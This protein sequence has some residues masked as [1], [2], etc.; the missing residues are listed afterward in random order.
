M[1][2]IVVSSLF[3]LAT[4]LAYGDSL[5][6]ETLRTQVDDYRQPA[7]DF[8]REF[9]SFPNDARKP[10]DIERL[11]VW[12][13]AEFAE[14]GFRTQR[15]PTAGSDSLYA[16]REVADAKRTVLIYLQADG[17]P[18]DPSAWQQPD[19]FVPVLKQPDGKGGFEIIPWDTPGYDPDWRV[20]ARS[21]SD[22]KG[23]MA[24]FLVAIELLDAAGWTQDYTLKVLI[25]TEE[26]LGSPHLAN[27]VV[28]NADLLAADFLLIFDGPPHASDRPT[29]SFGAR[30]IVTLTLT[31]Y[32]PKRAQH[33]GHYGNFMP[34][35]AL[36]LAQLLASMKDDDGRV[37][38]DGF[39]D[40]IEIDEATRAVLEAVP[41]DED[42]ILESVGLARRDDVAP[43]LQEAL[44]YPS[45]NIRGL[46]SAW[47]GDQVR[48]IIPPTAVAEIDIRLVKESD[49]QRLVGLVEAHIE[50]Q[51]YYVI[52]RPP[53]D[54]ERLE[55]PRIATLVHD[56][57]YNAFRSPYD[58]PAG[59]MARAALTELYDEPPVL[60]RTMGGS[61]PISPIVDALG[62]PAATVPTVNIDNNQ[63]SPNENLRLGSFY[64]GIA[65]L[66]AVLAQTP[67]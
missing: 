65:R 19:P 44:Q 57:S 24:Q 53:T 8:F 34:N 33:S 18:V 9:L 22:S 46:R 10:D 40:G 6:A 16:V 23:P 63:H 21:A 3:F 29:V 45:L 35:P 51:G 62:I 5:A 32:G 27:A 52:D 2:K 64:D 54:A 14:R 43:S 66:M 13:E 48:T 55:H 50:A 7:L 60:I 25:D 15:L 17:Q 38:I 47:T 12:L 1:K 39:Y 56:F 4:P 26:E 20:F 30:G 58:S 42:A 36:G 41:D 49:W 67:P 28:A 11:N 31:T 59:M 61:V 37:V